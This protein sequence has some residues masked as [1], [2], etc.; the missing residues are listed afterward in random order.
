ML[1]S[2]TVIAPLLFDPIE[3]HAPDI[4]L[5]Y[6]RPVAGNELC[7]FWDAQPDAHRCGAP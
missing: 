3:F 7:S 2:S 5:P 4:S 6:R 1:K